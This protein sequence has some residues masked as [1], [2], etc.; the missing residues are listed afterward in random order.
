MNLSC[1]LCNRPFK[2]EDEVMYIAFSY[3]NELPSKVNYSI[4]RPHEIDQESLQHVSC[5]EK[6]NV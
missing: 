1:N 2:N 5:R 6:T 3:W 4:S